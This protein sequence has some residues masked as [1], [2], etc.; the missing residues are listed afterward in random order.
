M[1]QFELF[2]LIFLYLEAQWE[3]TKDELFGDFLSSMNP[4]WFA[5][6]GSAVPHVYHDFC[7]I[8]NE[9][10]TVENSLQLAKKYIASLNDEAVSNAFGK[11]DPQEWV[12]CTAEYLAMDHK[13]KDEAR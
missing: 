7:K 12:D 2:S 9:P 1:N 5:N 8:I 13:G 11:V 10:I 4:F 3:E 6:I